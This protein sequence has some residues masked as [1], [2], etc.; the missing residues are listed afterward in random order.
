MGRRSF[1]FINNNSMHSYILLVLK[2]LRK[3]ANLTQREL[4]AKLGK[5]PDL[6]NKIECQRFVPSLNIIR[7]YAV[8]FNKSVSDILALAE[9]KA[10]NAFYKSA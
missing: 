8:F 6:V 9:D 7:D 1:V 10:K 5:H 4:S 3:N 2:D